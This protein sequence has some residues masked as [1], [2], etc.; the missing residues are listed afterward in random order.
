MWTYFLSCRLHV[1]QLSDSNHVAL[2]SLSSHQPAEDLKHKKQ[3]PSS[4]FRQ[5]AKETL[6]PSISPA[7]HVS[8]PVSTTVKTNFYDHQDG[9]KLPLN[10]QK[11]W[12]PTHT[13]KSD[14]ECFVLLASKST[15]WSKVD[16][17]SKTVRYL[18]LQILRLWVSV[19]WDS[20]IYESFT[21]SEALWQYYT[22]ILRH[23]K[24]LSL[25]FW[26]SEILRFWD[27]QTLRLWDYEI[28]KLSKSETL[29]L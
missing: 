6:K 13:F 11:P 12:V 22:E 27:S 21:D 17:N 3:Q 8:W 26:D 28:L 23:S 4:G 14:L 24:F 19:L 9:I 1:L 5:L 29:R 20:Q 10:H 16:K 18:A 7:N 2:E 25:R 15:H